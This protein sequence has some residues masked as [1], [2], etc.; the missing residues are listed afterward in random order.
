[1]N[2]FYWHDYETWGANPAVDRPSQFAGVRTDD[3]LNIISEPLVIY[4]RPPEDILP[5][6]EACLI[7]GITPQH[8][9]KN[10]LSEA[11]FIKRI[12][13]E[14]IQPGTCGVG[15]NS[16][17][18]DDEVT[19]YTLYRNFYDPYEREWRNGNSRWDIID[20]MR[21]VYAL[22]PEGIEWPMV[23]GVPSF[24]LERL[25]EAN[26]ISHE[27]AH[28]A[29]SDV[30]ATIALAKLVKMRKPE[31]YNYVLNNRSKQACTRFIDIKQKKPFLHISSRF[32]AAR[33]CC[34]LVVPLAV[35]PVNKNAVIVYELSVSPEPLEELSVEVLRE[36][37]FCA[38]DELPE[39]VER[40]PIKLI[41]L[42]KCPIMLPTKM[43][44]DE[45]ASRFGI[46]RD[47][48]ER[49]W[50]KI[51]GMELEYKLR[52]MY[53]QERFTEKQ[54]PEQ[55]LYSGFV[56]DADKALMARVRDSGAEEL[57]D[58]SFDFVDDRLNAILPL[59]RARNFPQ[60]LD[61]QGR[62]SWLE[63]KGMNL[64]EGGEGILTIDEY[65]NTIDRFEANETVPERLAIL[66]ELRNYGDA[67]FN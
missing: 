29:Y 19:R 38:K 17:R 1:M 9:L 48:C 55:R 35:H 45:L 24:K 65:N 31:L 6:P 51:R 61:E 58:A 8:A 15:Y 4:C 47:A 41:H 7:T 39:G 3:Q 2:T 49:N 30:A 21:M 5:H 37:V 62:Q 23:E 14:F 59:Y 57:A 34:G 46:D 18:F 32:P 63:H 22:R 67:L 43:L 26:G 64:L 11:E 44:S 12:H 54:D 10:G 20:M 42:N 13:A 16:L 56:G 52:Q 66:S 40:L 25:T 36:R 28:D 50:H 27:A 53:E 33:G 60:S